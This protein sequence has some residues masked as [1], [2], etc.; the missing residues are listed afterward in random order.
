M[1]AYYMVKNIVFLKKL[2]IRG[3]EFQMKGYK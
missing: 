1:H 3:R 2:Q